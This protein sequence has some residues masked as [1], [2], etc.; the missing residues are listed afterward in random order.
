MVFREGDAEIVKSARKTAKVTFA[1]CVPAVPVTVILK[2]LA[3]V[4]LIPLTVIVLL[5]PA[6]M[7][8]GSNEQAAPVVQPRDMLSTNELGAEA[9]MVKVV[10]LVPIWTTVERLLAESEKTGSPVPESDT[11]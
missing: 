6:V 2:G 5:S 3:V 10:V 4:A 1:D 11:R 8:G 7:V 9:L